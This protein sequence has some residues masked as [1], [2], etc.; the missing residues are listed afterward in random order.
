[1]CGLLF[2]VQFCL[3]QLINIVSQKKLHFSSLDTRN[4]KK[5]EKNNMETRENIF[6]IFMI[7]RKYN[8]E[9]MKKNH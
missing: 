1:M 4:A 2:T 8:Y 3:Q 5:N 7:V 6:S 9:I